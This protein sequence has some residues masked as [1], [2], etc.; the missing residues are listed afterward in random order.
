MRLGV[1]AAIQSP[2]PQ[3][4]RPTELFGRTREIVRLAASRAALTLLTGDSGV[5]KSAVL[6]A[7]QAETRD[8]I[9]PDPRSLPSSGGALQRLLIEGIAA[10]LAADTAARG[11]GSALAARLAGAAER[12]VAQGG[13]ALVRLIGQEVLALVR[14]Q[15]GESVGEGL[16]AY[17]A[18]LKQPADERLAVR[19]HNAVDRGAS[20]LVLSFAA[21]LLQSL[22]NQS[23]VLAFDAGERLAPEDVRVLA[24]IADGLPEG[25]RIRLAVS[26]YAG[27]RQDIV[28]ELGSVGAAVAD[29]ELKGIDEDGI[30]EWLDAQELTDVD[31]AQMQRATGGYALYLGDLIAHLKDGGE[32]EQAPLHEQLARRT[33]EAWR[34]LTA[35]VAGRARRLCVLA[36]PLEAEVT[37]SLL[38]LTLSEWAET[39]ERLQ[40]ARIFS[41]DVNG[42]PW[43]HEQRRRY[44]LEQK[45]ESEE[46]A[47]ACVD[48]VAVVCAIA[49]ETGRTDRL[50]ELAELLPHASALLEEN[51]QLRAVV[52]LDAPQLALCAAFVELSEPSMGEAP[53]ID[54][55]ALLRHARRVFEIPDN[56]IAA[57]RQL[58]KG[59]LVQLMA[60]EHGAI[61]R[62][63]LAEQLVVFAIIGRARRGLTRAPIPGAAGAVF[64]TVIRP[65]AEPFLATG[66]G[67]GDTRMAGLGAES[68]ELRRR[69]GALALIDGRDTGP[70]LL[71]RGHYGGRPFYAHLSFQEDSQRERAYNELHELRT[72]VLDQPFE[73]SDLLL[74]PLQA[75][76]AR[77]FLLAARRLLRGD[78]NLSFDGTTASRKLT[79]AKTMEERLETR[80]AVI[81]LVRERTTVTERYAMDI[82]KPIGFLFHDDRKFRHIA[83]VIGGR[84]DARPVAEPARHSVNEPFWAYM[85]EQ[86]GSLTPHER[87]AIVKFSMGGS[88]RHSDPAI[89]ALADLAKQAAHFNA[90]QQ[91][92]RIELN[93]LG[94]ADQI[95]QALNRRLDDA[96][97]LHESGL[98]G[99]DLDP[100]APAAYE[101]RLIQES[102]GEGLLTRAA[103]VVAR[104]TVGDRDR[105][106]VTVA[107]SMTPMSEVMSEETIAWRQGRAHDLIADLLG[108]RVDD[109]RLRY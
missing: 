53:M 61:A 74:H 11:P 2:V 26:T 71:L 58:G 105:V 15:L 33:E 52:A 70:N 41:I 43:F 46:R 51:E 81:R 30:R 95:E 9:A 93:D 4:A 36:D 86:S 109:V 38:G 78:L 79:A 65:R 54:A 12:V 28:D 48:G 100:P 47:A 14:G 42:R 25:M 80:A 7:A 3:P 90:V 88:D 18:A 84:E 29:I 98:F 64:E 69:L 72:E 82:D 91:R 40:R 35:E 31:A 16:E 5:G 63:L 17:A 103:E 104:S 66:Y 75:I 56:L 1:S 57:L 108:H 50:A 45:L 99:E 83:E 68:V 20:E 89:E 22:E 87:V 6:A 32:I 73:V 39:Q 55:Q 76:P 10:A 77:R 96:Q 85:I 106:T 97:A 67:I 34:G 60:Q 62:S 102:A 27:G 24:D 107:D 23:V 8:A 59:P 19:L 37:A 44:L 13:Q 21:E 92:V 94:L 49:Q 101:I